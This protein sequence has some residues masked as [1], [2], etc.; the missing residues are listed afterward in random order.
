[1]QDATQKYD[2][3]EKADILLYFAYKY[4]PTTTTKQTFEYLT[5]NYNV[6]KVDYVTDT[7]SSQWVT[8]G[9]T[10]RLIRLSDMKIISKDD[11][12]LPA[13]AVDLCK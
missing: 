4:L 10:K 2:I 13:E 8:V 6:E 5:S 9:P 11:N 7:S 1:V 12:L 3:L